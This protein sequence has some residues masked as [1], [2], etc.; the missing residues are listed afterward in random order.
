MKTI[1]I[2]GS[3][4]LVALGG[5]VFFV[6]GIAWSAEFSP[7][8]SG[9]V[10]MELQTE[11]TVSS[12]DDTTEYNNTFWRT[13]VVPTLQLTEGLYIDGTLV[14]EPVADFD[15]DESNFFENEGIFAEELKVNY[16]TGPVH[17][18]AGKFN[19]GFGTAWDWGRGVWGEDRLWRGLYAGG[20]RA[21][22]AHGQ[23][24]LCRH[25]VPFGIGDQEP[26]PHLEG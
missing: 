2:T 18:F 24:V 8:L 17:L 25:H 26:Q 15:T 22:Y 20:G 12:D 21:A 14:L 1:R 6:P 7:S 23:H 3:P 10:V 11:Q 16:D 4:L 9:D 5:L 13:E 19:P